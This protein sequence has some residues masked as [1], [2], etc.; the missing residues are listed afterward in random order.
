MPI[1]PY[2]GDVM[3]FWSFCFGGELR[4]LNCDDIGTCVV[5]KYFE[6]L[7]FVLIPFMLT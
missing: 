6:L 3:Y 7:E 4:F 2:G 5:N 1:G